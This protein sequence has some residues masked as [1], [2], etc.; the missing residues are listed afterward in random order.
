METREECDHG[1]TWT[2]R[3]ALGLS[4]PHGGLAQWDL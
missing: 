4:Q 2:G 1:E 3:D